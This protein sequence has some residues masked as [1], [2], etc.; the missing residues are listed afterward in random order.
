MANDSSY[1]PNVYRERGGNTFVIDSGGT[2]NHVTGGAHLVPF[3]FATSAA[4]TLATDGGQSGITFETQVV[5]TV[6][7]LPGATSVS[8]GT[9]YRFTVATGSSGGSGY[10][11]KVKPQSSD[12]IVGAVSGPTDAE[13]LT[14]ASGDKALGDNVHVVRASDGNWHISDIRGTWSLTNAT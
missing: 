13:V 8:Q 2:L 3:K 1:R 14:L 7:T 5:K 6:Y 9:N 12:Q 4:I 10:A 11:M